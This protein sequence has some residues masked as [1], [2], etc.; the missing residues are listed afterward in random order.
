MQLR[1]MQDMALVSMAA[2][3]ENDGAVGSV[4]GD[5]DMC[6]GCA[7]TKRRRHAVAPL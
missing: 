1:V 5:H 2:R 6:E 3:R 4:D 7:E